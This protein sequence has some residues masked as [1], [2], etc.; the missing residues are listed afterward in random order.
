M[1][2]L[3]RNFNFD[4]PNALHSPSIQPSVSPNFSSRV[5]QVETGLS[6]GKESILKET[7]SF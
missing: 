7:F 5:T 2:L 6:T 1:T 4:I 3:I